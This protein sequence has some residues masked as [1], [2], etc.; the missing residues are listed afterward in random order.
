[1]STSLAQILLQIDNTN[2]PFFYRSNSHGDWGVVQQ[3]FQNGD[4]DL[5]HF[6]QTKAL[7]SFYLSLLPSNKTP[8]IVDAGANIGASV[9]YFAGL[10]PK[11]KILAIEPE[12]KN[13]AL[14]KKNC[15][16]L[17]FALL[18][19]GIGC[20]RGRLYLKDPGRGD[21]GFVLHTD[22]EYPVPVFGAEPIIADQIAQGLVP[23]IFKIDIEGGEAELFREN[24]SWVRRFPLLII[25][26]HD[27][28]FPG[29]ANSRNFLRAICS[30]N[31]D[32]VIRG[33]N[34][35]CFNNDLLA[36]TS[37]NG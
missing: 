20:A 31:F 25:E 22:G 2:R 10:F 15:E 12:A 28:L 30:L 16:G 21:W 19:G 27:W 37:G 32:L 23:F 7:H 36:P 3:I 5:S 9:V 14:L 18:E 34:V 26:L 33:E 6:S 17:N 11:S 29:I 8:L 24:T 4:Y 13:C 35:F 1:M